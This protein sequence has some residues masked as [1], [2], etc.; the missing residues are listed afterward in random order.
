MPVHNKKKLSLLIRSFQYVY[1][2][3]KIE[4]KES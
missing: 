3:F 2:D 1:F 4:A